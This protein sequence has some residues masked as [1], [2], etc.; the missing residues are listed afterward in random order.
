MKILHSALYLKVAY[1]R[2]S[3]ICTWHF[4]V[5]AGWY[6]VIDK[7]GCTTHVTGIVQMPNC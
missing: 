3:L 6:E 5:Q 4:F 1:H 7:R 2:N